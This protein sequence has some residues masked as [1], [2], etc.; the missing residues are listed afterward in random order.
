MVTRALGGKTE[1]SVDLQRA[2]VNPGDMLL[3][4][5]DGLTSM[6]EEAEIARVVAA[7]G[8]DIEQAT[9]ALV[10]EANARGGHD[11]VTVMLLRF[12]EGPQ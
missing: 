5:S 9:R 6:L 8:G 1:L 12:E 10:A 2:V 11:N 3:L 7:A 4:C